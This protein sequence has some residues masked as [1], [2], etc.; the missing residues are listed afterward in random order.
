VASIYREARKQ[1][2]TTKNMSKYNS[3]KNKQKLA[4]VLDEIGMTIDD[5]K[6]WLASAPRLCQETPCNGSKTTTTDDDIDQS[7][8]PFWTRQHAEEYNECKDSTTSE[9][10]Q[11]LKDLLPKLCENPD[12]CSSSKSCEKAVESSATNHCATKQASNV[13]FVAA[14]DNGK[15][16]I[17]VGGVRVTGEYRATYVFDS[18]QKQATLQVEF[19]QPSF[20]S[21]EAC[22]KRCS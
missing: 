12:K 20:S 1:N 18:E 16:D 21:A 10:E 2:H 8:F 7:T 22:T 15:V 9:L 6:R 11:F 17:C 14:D 13:T 5:A 19:V 4:K 3:L